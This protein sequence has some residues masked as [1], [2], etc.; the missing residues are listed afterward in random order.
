MT[1]EMAIRIA[2][3]IGQYTLM[4]LGVCLI[5][6]VVCSLICEWLVKKGRI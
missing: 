5:V 4:G 3:T 6:M 2:V 1:M